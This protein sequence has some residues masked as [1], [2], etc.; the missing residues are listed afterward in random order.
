MFD[1]VWT[2]FIVRSQPPPPQLAQVSEL[3]NLGVFAHRFTYFAADMHDAS[4]Q[5]P[6]RAVDPRAQY[7]WED[8]LIPGNS[9]A[10]SSSQ[11]DRPIASSDL[12]PQRSQSMNNKRS[13]SDAPSSPSLSPAKKSRLEVIQAA[14][15]SRKS[16]S[17]P[18]SENAFPPAAASQD[19]SQMSAPQ[20]R[21]QRPSTPPTPSTLPRSHDV[22]PSQRSH[23]K[24]SRLA[25]I[26]KALETPN[27]FPSTSQSQTTN[28]TRLNANNISSDRWV[29]STPP[30]SQTLPNSSQQTLLTSTRT[31]KA[32]R[33]ADSTLGG[34]QQRDST[35]DED[36]IF[37]SPSGSQSRSKDFHLPRI[38]RAHDRFSDDE[39]QHTHDRPESPDIYHSIDPRQRTTRTPATAWNIG[40]S[41]RVDPVDDDDE[42]FGEPPA[43][44]VREPSNDPFEEM[45]TD[46]RQYVRKLER[47]KI[48]MGKSNAAKSKKISELELENH[49]STERAIKRN[50]KVDDNHCT[51]TFTVSRWLLSSACTN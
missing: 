34:T 30:S 20:N 25:V 15:T 17:T 24:R 21:A 1:V 36:D 35:E 42:V 32:Q 2:W 26:Q 12:S 44:S 40:P 11:R 14:L 19:P 33:L 6:A 8:E 27:S 45:V 29:P 37:L 51:S 22:S 50:A 48:A 38:P 23:S 31:S 28:S 7:I 10:T 49:Q 39:E 46:L 3:L 13:H 47:Q 41:T 43:R 4:D 16:D 18:E 5:S 9:E